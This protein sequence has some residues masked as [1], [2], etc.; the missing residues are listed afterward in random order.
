MEYSILR[1]GG[2]PYDLLQ[3]ARYLNTCS[4]WQLG[5]LKGFALQHF[6]LLR[7]PLMALLFVMI[8]TGFAGAQQCQ[9]ASGLPLRIG[10]L[11]VMNTL[12]L[13]V[14]ESDG[15]YADH[16]I[17]VE[18]VPIESARD[19][20]IGLQTG[21]LDIGN[22]DVMGATLQVAAGDNLKIIRHDPFTAGVPFFSIVV[23]SDLGL[24][25]PSEFITALSEGKIQIAVGHNTVTEYMT[26][27]LLRDHG[28]NPR[29]GDYIEV[30]AIPLRLEQLMQGTVGAALLPEPL[31]SLAV[32]TG[33]GTPLFQDSSTDFVPVVLT[34]RQQVI[35][36]R[37]GDL[38]R[39]LAAYEDAVFAIN[40]NPEDYRFN[41]IRIPDPIIESYVVPTFA[42]ARVPN[43]E[44]I[45]SVIDWMI[46]TN[47]LDQEVSYDQLV[48]GQFIKGSD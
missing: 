13:F 16:G 1:D 30:S 44:E 46:E 28:Y 31:T 17:E 7:R 18:L 32:E 41:D 39:F 47:M 22:N 14:A 3:Y 40:S 4:R 43:R 8:G 36:E 12:P 29:P 27:R 42:A 10:V 48:D 9:A 34:A 38:C 21:Q 33:I 23:R 6:E 5:L 20:S 19:R 35:N 45:Q 2:R 37:P 25:T 15:F 26:S 11:P 24:E